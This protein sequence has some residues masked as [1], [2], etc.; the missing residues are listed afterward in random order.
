MVSII[1]LLIVFV[2]IAIRDVSNI[3][4]KIWETMSLGALIVLVTGQISFKDALSAINVEVILFLF[5]MFVIGVGLEESGYLEYITFHIFKR[6]KNK[7]QIILTLIF[8]MGLLSAILMNDTIAIIG[9]PILIHLSNKFNFNIKLLLLSLAFSI[10]IGS[11]TSPLG[12]PQNFLIATQM[13]NPFFY[14]FKYLFLP[15]LINL[16]I[17]FLMLRLFYQND[18]KGQIDTNDLKEEIKDIN[19]A[20]VSRISV[21]LLVFFTVL[22]IVIGIID[23][24]HNIPLIY[25][26]IFSGLPLIIFSKRRI[27]I[28]KK[29]DWHTL[30]FFVSMFILMQSVWNTGFFQSIVKSIGIDLSSKVAIILLSIL[31]SQF[32]SNVPLVVL[33]LPIILDLGGTKELIALAAGSTIAGNL[34]ILGAASNVIIIHNAE[35]RIGIGV[36]FFE[37]AKIGI[38]MTIINTLVYLFFLSI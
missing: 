16:F 17:C 3:K 22:K 19:L 26:V 37:F 28:I 25:I 30:I 18:F 14:F 1:V 29:V 8:V 2:L 10:T 11:L 7:K 27:E 34:S 38:P 15:T 32:I 6:A 4:L 20:K 33:L 35:K 24:N 9:T 13:I 23:N 5:F 21:I 12:N 31:I 36:G